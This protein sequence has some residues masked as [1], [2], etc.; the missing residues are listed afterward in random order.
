MACKEMIFSHNFVSS[1]GF[2]SNIVAICPD[3]TYPRRVTTDGLYNSM[4]YWSP[5]GSQIAYLSVRS[6][7]QQLHLMDLDGGNDR[8]LTSGS[9][10]DAS[11]LVWLPDGNRIAIYVAG[12]GGW[13]WQAV[14]VA[15]GKITPLDEWTFQSDSF[16][17]MKLSH[18]GTRLAYLVQTKPE[19]A[20]SPR[21]IYIQD[22]DGSNAYALTSTNWI[23]QNPIWSPDDSQIAF[24]SSGEHAT[25]KN[26]IYTINLDG[27]N[28]HELIKTDLDPWMIAWSPDGESLA[29]YADDELYTGGVLY[30]VEI[31]TGERTALFKIEEPNSISH[32]SWSH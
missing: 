11:H 23:I 19:Q 28:L 26:A 29:V 8:Q 27:S 7:T 31:K 9:G 16:M 12:I 15:T 1:N 6:G 17:S 3:E 14:D 30:E 2:G 24:H 22:I 13:Q 20:H 21:E 4:P 32:L 25:C 5:D 18:D 10:L